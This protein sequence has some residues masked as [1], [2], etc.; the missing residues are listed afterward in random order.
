MPFRSILTNN[1]NSHNSRNISTC[2][3]ISNTTTATYSQNFH[4]N[5]RLHSKSDSSLHSSNN[6]NSFNFKPT[7]KR[8]SL[9][10]DSGISHNNE[11]TV[12]S[13]S[14]SSS[15]SSPPNKQY[16][17]MLCPPRESY[18]IAEITAANLNSKNN[19]TENNSSHILASGIPRE[20][21][22]LTS[23]TENI[24]KYHLKCPFFLFFFV[25]FHVFW[26]Y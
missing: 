7:K 22:P 26:W 13:S 25:F 10:S 19:I 14:S 2:S 15:S 21:M 18:D 12:S 1:N 9:H 16:L 6:N 5:S 3:N 8:K 11:K 24:K 23:S 17:D 4:T 20:T